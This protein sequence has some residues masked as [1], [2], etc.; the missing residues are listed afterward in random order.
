MELV[1]DKE[2]ALYW[3]SQGAQPSEPVKRLFK[4]AGVLPG[5]EAVGE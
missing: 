3:L 2:K 5:E 1:V 4:K